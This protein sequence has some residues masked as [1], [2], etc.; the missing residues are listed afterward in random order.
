MSRYIFDKP[1]QMFDW[2]DTVAKKLLSIPRDK[3]GMVEINITRSELGCA[4]PWTISPKDKQAWK[5]RFENED[6]RKES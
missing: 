1:E 3:F 2:I 5:R 6:V 4:Y